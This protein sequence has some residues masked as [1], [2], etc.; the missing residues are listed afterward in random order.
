[1]LIHFFLKKFPVVANLSSGAVSVQR[2]AP[3]AAVLDV[4]GDSV[5]ACVSTRT[6]PPR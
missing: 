3:G 1:M 2:H 5:I 4:A 6:N